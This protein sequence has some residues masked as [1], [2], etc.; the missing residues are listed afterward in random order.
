MLP[1][2]WTDDGTTLTAKNGIVVVRG[3]RNKVLDA[4][5]WDSDDVPNTVEFHADQVL[6]HRP[7]LG[8]GQVQTFRDH[9]M[10]FTSTRGVVLEK[11][12]GLEIFL[13]DKKIA[14]LEAQLAA[15]GGGTPPPPPD[16]SA[17]KAALDAVVADL[18]KAS[19]DAQAAETDLSNLK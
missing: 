16:T 15:G 9:Y 7:D 1:A 18:Q 3:F 2:G 19:T 12:L 4:A 8:A 13:R 5:S 6:Y 17:L 11:E 10:W 14:D